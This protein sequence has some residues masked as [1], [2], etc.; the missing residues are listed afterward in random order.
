MLSQTIRTNAV[1]AFLILL[2]STS[3]SYS[4][5]S[6][7]LSLKKYYHKPVQTKELSRLPD[8]RK[9]PSGA[10]RKKAF[11]KAIVPIIEKYNYK[12]MQNRQ[13][14]LSKRSSK[15]WNAA[16]LQ[17]LNQICTNYNVQC[18]SPASLNWNNLLSRVDIIP[19]HFVVTQAATESGWGASGLAQ[20]NN[21]LFGM[22]CSRKC[23]YSKGTIKGYVVYSS[24]DASINAYLKNLNTNNAYQSLRNSRAQQRRTQNSLN[25]S[26]LIDN[27]QNYSQLGRAYNRYLQQMFSNNE[28]LITQ[29]QQNLPKH[30]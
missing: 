7:N 19:I 22:K 10:A 11:L 16:D 18:R 25:T 30:I 17:R 12:I 1:F 9:Y 20:K 4:S 21:N 24:V 8:M 15:N 23:T 28:E 29:V 26:V 6:T 5:T 14:L 13:W 2:F 3:F 27:M